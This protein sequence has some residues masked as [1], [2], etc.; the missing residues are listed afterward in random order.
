MDSIK[1]NLAK[2]M[3]FAPQFLRKAYNAFSFYLYVLLREFFE[4]ELFLVRYKV[5]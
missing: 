3:N 2:V 4:G 5:K 1:R